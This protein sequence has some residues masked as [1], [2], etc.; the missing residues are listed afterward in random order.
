MINARDMSVIG[1]DKVFGTASTLSCCDLSITP[2][3]SCTTPEDVLK[4]LQVFAPTQG[5]LCL[6]DDV[7]R[8]L[9][10][11]SLPDSGI[12]FYG[13][14]CNDEASL[15]IQQRGDGTWILTTYQ[16]QA[17]ETLLMERTQ[18][19]GE[20]FQADGHT[21]YDLQYRVYWG[22]AESLSITD[23]GQGWRQ[24]AAVFTGFKAKQI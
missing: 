16:Q 4:A 8:F 12:V 6:Q 19:I 1:K 23:D 20:E 7:Y 18:L 11:Q 15:H 24:V 21:R 22:N 9:D 17:G 2:N 5:W 13:E 10:A 14:V 3:T